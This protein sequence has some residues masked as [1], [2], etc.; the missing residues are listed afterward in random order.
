M[1]SS[2]FWGIIGAA[3]LAS[4][5]HCTFGPQIKDGVALS[6]TA[7][8]GKKIQLQFERGDF[9]IHQAK[10]GRMKLRIAPQMAVWAEDSSGAVATLYVT[11]CFAKQDWK[12]AKIDPNECGRPTCMPYW[13]NRLKANKIAAPTKNNPLPDAISGA[14]PTGSFTLTSTLPE[15]FTAGKIYVEINKSFDNNDAWPVKK[16][17][18]SFNGQPP[19]V[20][21]ALINLAD[22]SISSWNLTACGISGEKGDDPKLYPLDERLTTA[23]KMITG[24]TVTRL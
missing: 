18:S 6:T 8:N 20:Y 10:L 1:K 14:T 3:L 19:V 15:T 5:I 17:M 2:H 13:L 16:D 22:S 4:S 7:G 11:H 21:E 12:F 24:I 9:W 23:L